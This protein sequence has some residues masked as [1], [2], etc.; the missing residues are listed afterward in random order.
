MSYSVC[1]KCQQPVGYYDK[2]C[3]TCQQKYGLPD[4]PEFQRDWK[5]P[6]GPEREAAEKA[7]VKKDLEALEE[8][9]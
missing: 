5:I 9:L 7:E 1:I 4:L 6:Y 8:K 3:Q 2:Y